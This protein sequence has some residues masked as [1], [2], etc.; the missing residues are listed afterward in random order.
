M[1]SSGIGTKLI[2]E[3]IG[4]TYI[5]TGLSKLSEDIKF[6]LLTPLGSIPG[7][8]TYGSNIRK[9]LFNPN[10]RATADVLAG[11]V[12]TILNNHPGITVN[13]VS[14]NTNTEGNSIVIS[15]DIEYNATK[16][17]D[18]ITLTREGEI[19]L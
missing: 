15:Y 10:T 7:N 14:G 3:A 1:R 6:K 19:W 11:E 17:S 13:N 12:L 4:S 5:Y 9:I 18:D 8:P 16:I 2:N